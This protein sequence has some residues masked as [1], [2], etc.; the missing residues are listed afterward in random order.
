MTRGFIS[1]S[2]G[3]SSGSFTSLSF[4]WNL[5]TKINCFVPSTCNTPFPNNDFQINY[6]FWILL[7][8]LLI[9]STNQLF[10]AVDVSGLSRQSKWTTHLPNRGPEASYIVCLISM[11][12]IIW[13][14]ENI[15]D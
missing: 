7:I 9:D 10:G 2:R 3:I 6:D 14:L 8:H 5:Q 4:A 11:A 12:M 15:F 13:Y 1:N